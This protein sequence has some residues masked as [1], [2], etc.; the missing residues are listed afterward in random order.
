MRG[1]HLHI[2]W[3]EGGRKK[4]PDAKIE[5]PPAEPLRH[6]SP[7]HVTKTDKVVLLHLLISL[8]LFYIL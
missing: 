3:G 8:S 7:T 4:V 5:A 1:Q 6:I 2:V